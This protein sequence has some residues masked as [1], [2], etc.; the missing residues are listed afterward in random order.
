MKRP[1]FLSILIFCATFCYGQ[2]GMPDASFGTGGVYA[3]QYDYY[4]RA[5][6]FQISG[7]IVTCSDEMIGSNSCITR[8]LPNGSLDPTFGT[9]GFRSVQY[10]TENTQSLDISVD[11]QN[12]IW[13]AGYKSGTGK[14]GILTKLNGST[15]TFNSGFGTG[16]QRVY[17]TGSQA[18]EFRSIYTEPPGTF[19]PDQKTLI[20]GT[21]SE[22]YLDSNGLAAS[23]VRGLVGRVTM[24]G[25]PDITFG[26]NGFVL[27]DP[28]YSNG[29]LEFYDILPD[30]H[31]RILACGYEMRT[32]GTQPAVTFTCYAVA[33]RF[34]SDGTLD[35]TF[36]NNGKFYYSPYP[37]ALEYT[38]NIHIGLND[39]IVITGLHGYQGAFE[40]LA[41]KL[42]DDGSFDT[43]FNS[44]G[45]RQISYYSHPTTVGGNGSALQDDGKILLGGAVGFGIDTVY[46]S[47]CRL[48]SDGSLDSAFGNA[49]PGFSLVVANNYVSGAAMNLYL[50][51]GY[52]NGL[53]GTQGKIVMV[54]KASI[55][56][57]GV[58]QPPHIT[59]V[60]LNNALTITSH[61]NESEATTALECGPN[62]FFDHLNLLHLED[63]IGGNYSLINLLGQEVLSGNIREDRLTVEAKTVPPG[64]YFLSVSNRRNRF[65]MLVSKQ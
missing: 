20:A 56:A 34:L 27:L 3:H 52:V 14:Y 5:L 22:I 54:G 11:V 63:F 28:F 2:D 48:Q 23:H 45:V 41:I 46:F 40:F 8:Y 35:T 31:G 49:S 39:E 32:F 50:T 42:L 25:T 64:N 51:P 6:A 15:G 59:L 21:A 47:A 24:D 58:C 44:T 16:G 62:P 1:S 19:N 36:A 57:N 13:V 10:G 38:K 37:D 65:S 53:T 9:N 29:Q 60:R 7:N 43:N 33:V 4:G 61:M 30:N 17:N 12:N 18:W 55:C 26:Q